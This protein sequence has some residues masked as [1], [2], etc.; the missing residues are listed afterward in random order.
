MQTDEPRR[1]VGRRGE[2]GDADAARVG[3]EDRIGVGTLGQGLPGGPL[4]GFVLEDRLDDDVMAGGA[5]GAFCGADA[6][7]DLVRDPLLELA[8]LDLARQVSGDALAAPVGELGRPVRERHLLSGGRAD[9]GDAV[10]HQAGADD[11]DPVDAHWP[12]SVPAAVE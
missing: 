7:Q 8:L 4:D 10:A 12:A 3:G 5:I 2:A 6:G 9:L 11:E 1:A